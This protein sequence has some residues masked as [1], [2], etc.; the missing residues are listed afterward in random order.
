MVS[1]EQIDKLL[2]ARN[3]RWSG[4]VAPAGVEKSRSP[5]A[6]PSWR[7]SNDPTRTPRRPGSSGSIRSRAATPP[8][9]PPDHKEVIA[10]AAKHLP[11]VPQVTPGTM[12]PPLMPASAYKKRPQ[13]PS[14]KAGNAAPTSKTG[15]TTPRARRHSQRSDTRS[16]A[17]SPISRRSSLSSFSSEIDQ[18]FNIPGGPSLVTNGLPPGATDPRMIQA[19]TQT[20]I[21]EFL[22]KY[23]RKTGREGLSENRH[24]RFF[25]IHPYTRTL[26]WSD[27]DP[28]SAGKAELKA[29]SVAIESVT[30]VDDGNPLPPGL[31]QKSLLVMTPGRAMKFTATTGQR[32]ETWFNALNY[33]CQRVDEGEDQSQA[34]SQPHQEPKSVAADEIQDEFNA[35]YRSSSR[36]TGRSRASMSSYISRRTTSPHHAQVPTLRQS[37]VARTA[38]TEQMQGSV[39]SRFSS[40]LRPTSAMRGSFSSRR[41][42][43]NGQEATTYEEPS[44]SNMELSRDIHEHV[45]RDLDGM[46]NVRACCDG[47]KFSFLHL[48]IANISKGKHDVGHLHQHSAKGRHGSIMSSRPSIIGSMSS[49]TQS[50]TQ[51]RTESRTESRNQSRNERIRH[52][53][54]M[55]AANFSAGA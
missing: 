2:L 27:K 12:G 54:E 44:T 25:W 18:R 47:K 49:R 10:A 26:Y 35:G 15:G 46:P 5:P 39:S 29:K 42:K 17:S 48:C 4:T 37:T 50:R 45:E 8:P 32:H 30:E 9:L 52:E 13:T 53:T 19:I 55:E 43:I 51:S 1:A 7:S 31:H 33:L 3:P 38:S 11:S 22:W 21:G 40:I 14:I 23:T 24:R 41:S 6:S 16:G 34:A 28:Q 20:M 36:Q